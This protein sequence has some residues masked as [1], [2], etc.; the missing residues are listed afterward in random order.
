MGWYFL[1]Q[2]I[3]PT[4][5]STPPVPC[6]SCLAGGFF[7]TEPLCALPVPRARADAVWLQCRLAASPFPAASMKSADP[8]L[9]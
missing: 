7:T 6:V 4:Q 5:G 1:L 3:F 9:A 8:E 2:G